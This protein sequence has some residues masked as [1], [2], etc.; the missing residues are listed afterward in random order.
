MVLLDPADTRLV[1]T[2]IGELGS[3]KLSLLRFRTSSDRVLCSLRIPPGLQKG[4]SSCDRRPP[5]DKGPGE[6][7]APPSDCN[8]KQYLKYKALKLTTAICYCLYINHYLSSAATASDHKMVIFNSWY[9]HYS[10]TC[11][12]RT[13]FGP[14]P[15]FEID[16][17]LVYTGFIKDFLYWDII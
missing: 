1:G 12:N 9:S 17:W 11:L 5:G 7:G 4:R 16:R 15:V 3:V 2:L 6:W 13:S 10:E 8:R 14:T